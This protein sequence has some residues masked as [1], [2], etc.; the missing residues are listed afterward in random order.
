MKTK[1]IL[2]AGCLGFFATADE[3]PGGCQPGE[4]MVLPRLLIVRTPVASEGNPELITIDF[5]KKIVTVEDARAALKATEGKAWEKM[6]VAERTKVKAPDEVAKLF[7]ISDRTG[8]CIP[9]EEQTDAHVGRWYGWR[10]HGNYG[11]YGYGY[12]RHYGYGS[13]ASYR[14]PSYGY[15]SN[16]SY[17]PYHGSG[18]SLTV[19]PFSYSYYS[20]PYYRWP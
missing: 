2:L 5:Q 16:N 13:Y 17:Y 19:G 8:V 20:N 6:E 14:Y 10:N 9:D 4:K 18:V 15:Y 7:D 11:W 12:G 1:W 3:Q